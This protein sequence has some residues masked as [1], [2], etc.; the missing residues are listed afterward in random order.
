MRR[1]EIELPEDV[2]RYVEQHPDVIALLAGRALDAHQHTDSP[3]M[4]ERRVRFR[5]YVRDR[6]EFS[7]SEEA[8]V[9]GAEFLARFRRV[10]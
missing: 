8:A 3:A 7:H 1:P 2:A 5:G 4:T 6:L 10:G 9:A